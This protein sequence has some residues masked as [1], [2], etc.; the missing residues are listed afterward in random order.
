MEKN[1][2]FCLLVIA[3]PVVFVSCKKTDS[4]S[5]VTPVPPADTTDTTIAPAIDPEPAKTIGFFNDDWQAKTFSAPSY[6]EATIPAAASV[7]VIINGSDIITKIPRSEFGHNANTWM[8][9]MITEPLFIN[10]TTNLHPHIIRFPA[11]SLSDAFF[12]NR[13]QGD[14]P[15]DA[16]ATI[17]N[18]DGAMVAPGYIYGRTSNNWSATLDNYYAML[19]QTGNQG[20]LTVNY[21]YARYGTGPNPVA[22]AAHLAADW[23]RYDNGRT[24]YWEIGNENFGDWEWGY[25]IN[26]A[27]NHDGQPEYLTG[28]LYAQHFKVFAD[29]MKKAATEIG[30]TIYIGAVTAEAPATQPW[31]TNT[32]RTWNSGMIPG[33]NNAADF[34]VVHSYFTP[35]NTNSNATDILGYAK[36]VPSEIMNYVTQTLTTYG[37][38]IKPIAMDEWNMFAVNSM[39]QV[40]NISGLFSVVVMG[41]NLKNKFGL[42]ARWDMLNGWDNGND[43]GL[44]S[45]GDEPGVAKWSPRPSFYYLYFFQKLLGDRMISNTV[46]GSTNLLAYASSFSSGE[47]NVALVN[48]STTAQTVEVKLKNFRMGNRFYWY[49]LQGDTDNGEFSR[50]VSVNGSGPSGVAGGP[51]DYVT[52]KANS[53]LTINGMKVTVPARGAVILAVDKK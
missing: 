17:M 44:F 30:K 48:T 26:T 12:W 6:N 53:S 37:A 10:H 25:R 19:Q 33:L 29:S 9:P 28:Q 50:K 2:L 38:T 47:A 3:I 15:A 21:G 13:L 42:S 52:L 11:G 32:L 41:E 35:Y 39:Q 23:V 45:A 51:A 14:N 34:Y 1:R 18:K 36:S 27:N 7:T 8:T 49:S 46:T 40:S 4:G 16:P 43:H 5:G 31:Q 24:K 22:A 20:L